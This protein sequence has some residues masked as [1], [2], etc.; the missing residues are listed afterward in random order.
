MVYFQIFDHFISI[1]LFLPFFL[2]P[3]NLGKT[4]YDLK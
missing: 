3:A 2:S 1:F 4:Q